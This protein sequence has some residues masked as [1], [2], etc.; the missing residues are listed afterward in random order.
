L[1]PD[2]EG[3]PPALGESPADDDAPT[4]PGPVAGPKPAF[5]RLADDFD[6]ETGDD[7]RGT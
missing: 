7:R 3:A 5:E 2:P 4:A 1:P 6:W